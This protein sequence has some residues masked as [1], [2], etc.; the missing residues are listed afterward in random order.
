MSRR[1]DTGGVY[2]RGEV[3]WIHYRVAGERF[4]ESAETA[5]KRGAQSLLARRRRELRE[6]TWTR[7]KEASG[8]TLTVARWAEE[9]IARRHDANVH[10]AGDEET[11][12]R[13]W[14][15]PRL[16]DKPIADVKRS[17]VRDVIAE[18]QRTMSPTTGRPYAARTVL[19]VY[20]VMRLLFGDALADG[21][22]AASPCTLRT[23]KGE[24][25]VKRDADPQWRA[26]AIYTRDEA[27]MLISDERIPHDRR[28]YYALQL[29]TGMRAQEVAARRWR[30]LD[31]GAEPLGRMLVWSQAVKHAE[32]PTKTGEVKSVPIHPTLAAILGEWRLQG[33][34]LFFGRHPQPDDLIVPNRHDVRTPR[35]KKQLV[36]LKDDLERLGLRSEGRGRHAMRATFLTLLESDGANMAIARRTTHAAPS[37]VVSGYI[38]TSWTDLCREVAKL[39]LDLRRG[40]V[41]PIKRKAASDESR[42]YI[43]GDNPSETAFSLGEM[44]GADG[45]RTRGLR[46]DRPAL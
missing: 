40:V 24:L 17:D 38:R 4:F 8:A 20:G 14:V 7:P 29:F 9:W 3:Y 39:R 21:L 1:R 42:G 34:A 11:R 31:F 6:G 27:E 36:R 35:A 37:D 32:R 16:G 5:D 43:R 22:I 28:V 23:R 15:I 25:P 10:T 44:N 12:L 46:R 2:L 45:T 33:F 13:M 30:D 41:V 18:M 19:H 26:Q